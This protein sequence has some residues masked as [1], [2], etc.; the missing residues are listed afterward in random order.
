MAFWG[1]EV[2]PGKPFTLSRHDG[3]G[4]LHISQATLGIGTAVG[5]TMV[6]CNVGDKSPVFLCSL[7]TEK[8]ESC[9]LNLEFEE[10]ENVV[11]S[12]LGPRSVHL[13]GYYLRGGWHRNR[14]DES[15]SYGED[16]ADSE[17]EYSVDGSDDK[18]EDSFIDDEEANDEKLDRGSPK[19]VKSNS[20]RLKKKYQVSE[21]DDDYNPQRQV[22]PENSTDDTVA[23][24]ENED[25][26]PISTIYKSKSPSKSKKSKGK[27][28]AQKET[29]EAYKKKI[30]DEV[31]DAIFQARKRDAVVDMEPKIEDRR[32]DRDVSKNDAQSKTRRKEKGN[33]KKMHDS[34]EKDE[35]FFGTELKWNKAQQETDV[36]KLGQDL[37][38]MNAKDQKNANDKEDERV[39]L[40]S[41]GGVPNNIAKPKKKSKKI[42]KEEKSI[43][44]D[45]VT[46]EDEFEQSG[47]KSEGTGQDTSVTS[48]GNQKQA[49]D[50]LLSSHLVPQNGVK[51]KRKKEKQAAETLETSN[52]NQ[53]KAAIGNEARDFV[54][55]IVPS[56]S[57]DYSGKK[58][59]QK[60]KIE[61]LK[62]SENG[63]AQNSELPS[64]LLDEKNK[65]IEEDKN[66]NPDEM[67][68][69]SRTL[70]NGLVIQEL[71]KGKLDGRIATEGKKIS[72]RYTGKLN[73][74]EVFTSN[75]DG[76][77]IKFRLGGIEVMD[78]WNV[79]IDGM[80]VGEKRRLLVPP[81]LG[82]GNEGDDTKNIP[83]NSWLV[84]DIELVKVR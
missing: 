41:T 50:K 73:S 56:D 58:K 57:G 7:F 3:G 18:Y 38:V 51:R 35:F 29:D 21:S 78:A 63:Q 19:S 12:V 44:V 71:R 2:K 66:N 24:S 13:T 10:A 39:S 75:I 74:G 17:P 68:S 30:K 45:I 67:P 31:N 48:G 26:N 4:R 64:R 60:K 37:P 14:D 52:N 54:Y 55:N 20:R 49:N 40:P 82:Y 47:A 25:M 79:G 27:E 80:R 1:I 61:T 15:E 53:S 69:C 9:Q 42:A 11:L 5:K 34:G 23:D 83:P 32:D 43:E 36:D 62:T 65:S 8:D 46:T 72:I 77:P 33:N 59:K 70:P 76:T 28:K 16:I 84:Y 22:F 81:L 6:Q